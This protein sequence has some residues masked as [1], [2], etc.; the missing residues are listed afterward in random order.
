MSIKSLRLLRDWVMITQTRLA[1][2][3]RRTGQAGY[4]LLEIL[5]V[6]AIIS[7]LM[8]IVGPRVLG[9]VDQSK[10]V[11]TKTQAKNLKDALGIYRLRAGTYPDKTIGLQVLID[12]P[13]GEKIL[14]EDQI[15]LDAWGNA[16]HYEPPTV[17]G[18]RTTSVKVYSLGADNE[19][20]G[21][22]L[23]ADIYG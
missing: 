10:V 2:S 17:E 7:A 12:P 8:A 5:V 14:D 13:V 18:G 9:H 3:Q 20:G 21:E 1:S 22:G 4:S 6:L 16:F 19:P 15:P 11:S 23:N